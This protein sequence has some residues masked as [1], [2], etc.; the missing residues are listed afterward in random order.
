MKYYKLT[1]QEGKT[2]SGTV[3]GEGITHQPTGKG[4]ELCT[5][6]VIHV[7]D[8]PLKAAMFNPMHAKFTNPRL[9]ECQVRR[10][11]ADDGLKVGVKHCTTLKEIPLPEITTKQRVYFALLVALEVYTEPLFIAWAQDWLSGKDRTVKAARTAGAAA[12]AAAAAAAAWAAAGAAAWAAAAAAWAAA[13]AAAVAEAWVA[14]AAAKAAGA[15]A[16]AAATTLDL[17]TLVK[18][19]IREER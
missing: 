14:G 3:W 15:A 17:V 1:N 10:V 9:W 13:G 7:Y 8:H 12:K 18:Q 6:D 2:Y 11:V 4:K 16:E 19:A 5:A